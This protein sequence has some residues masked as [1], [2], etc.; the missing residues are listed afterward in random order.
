MPEHGLFVTLIF[1]YKG[2]IEDSYS[3]LLSANFTKS[4]NTLKKFVAKLPANC[5][6]VFDHFVGMAFKGLAY[7]TLYVV[8]SIS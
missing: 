6:S 4:S 2:R 3:S 1:L 5:L 7:F 8:V